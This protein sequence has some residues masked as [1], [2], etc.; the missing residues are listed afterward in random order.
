MATR[1]VIDMARRGQ[2][3]HRELRAARKQT[4]DDLETPHGRYR[5]PERSEANRQEWYQPIDD[6]NT[7][8]LEFHVWRDG[9]Q[10][11][12]FVI[13]IQTIATTGWETPE[14][15]D[16][17]HGHCHLHTVDGRT[18]TLMT[19]NVVHDVETAFSMALEDAHTRA[20]SLWEE[21]T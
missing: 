20:S 11:V 4:F 18:E 7:V 14:Y 13:N 6:T 19:L 9:G 1:M 12:E 5:P 8:R 16:C 3:K 10:I 2:Q 21:G 15:I 17:C